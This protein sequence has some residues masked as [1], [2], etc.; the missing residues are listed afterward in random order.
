MP[1]LPKGQTRLTDQQSTT[2]Q[3]VKLGDGRL[4]EAKGMVTVK[5]EMTLKLDD[6]KNATMHDVLYVPKLAGN[7]FVGA[8]VKKRKRSDVQEILLLHK[9]QGWNP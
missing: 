3:S 4:V 6:V 8:A 7:P 1:L 5:I 9:R 2:P